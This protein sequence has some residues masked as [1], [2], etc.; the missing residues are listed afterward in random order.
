MSLSVLMTGNRNDPE[1]EVAL[2]N[3]GEQDVSLNLGIMLANGKVQLP[4]KIHLNLTDGSGRNRELLFTY[5]AVAGRV[6]VYVVPLRAGST[7]T[8]KLRLDQFW[9]PSPEE[10]RLKLKPGRYEVL[11]QFQG[12]G[13][14]TS[15]LDMAGMKLMDFWKGKLQSNVVVFVE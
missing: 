5:P 9:S 14:E 7:Y 2:R 6:D 12:D 15:N 13:A 11:A 10:F 1:F 4:G 8:L 3:M